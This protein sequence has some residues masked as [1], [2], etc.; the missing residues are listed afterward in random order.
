VDDL[1]TAETGEAYGLPG[2]KG[3]FQ[4]R[5]NGVQ[6]MF[7]L[8]LGRQA[9]LGMNFIDK[10]SFGH[11]AFPLDDVGGWRSESPQMPCVRLF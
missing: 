9:G 8:R 5:K 7:R 6:G 10:F 11:G 1:K 4:Y 2:G 3:I